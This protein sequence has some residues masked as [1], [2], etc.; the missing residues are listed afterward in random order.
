MNR[1]F[2][3]AA[4]VATAVMAVSSP[5]LAAKPKTAPQPADNTPVVTP[6]ATPPPSGYAAPSGSVQA[7]PIGSSAPPVQAYSVPIAGAAQTPPAPTAPP[8]PPEPG[9][10]ARAEL[11]LRSRVEAA[12]RGEPSAKLAT[13]L[14]LQDLCA[15]E[16]D[17]ASLYVR[18]LD[19]LARFN[20]V[21]ERGRAGLS[22]ASVDPET[23]QILAPPGVDISA[24]QDAA[25]RA[26]S[27]V[28]PNLR[29]YAAEL[30]LNEKTRL[31]A[32]AKKAR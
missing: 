11:C 9:V 12:V 17:S 1:F 7:A 4:F 28:A 5:S 24:A 22:T 3:T 32:P 20:P 14:L 25:A 18:N 15:A 10:M 13:D 8:P 29:R 21:S 2:S 31:A 19:A 26:P 16:V 30:V 6:D 23:G 27:L